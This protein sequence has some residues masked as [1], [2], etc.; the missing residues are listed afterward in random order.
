MKKR[1]HLAIVAPEFPPMTCEKD[2]G[3]CCGPVPVSFKKLAEVRAYC[4]EHGITPLVQDSRCPLFI[5]NQCAIHPIRPRVCQ[6]YGH[7]E[8]LS[9]SRGHDRHVQDEQALMKW[10][11]AD[12]MPETTLHALVGLQASVSELTARKLSRRPNI[13]K[14]ENL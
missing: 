8:K 11:I 3:E 14:K 5:K 12:G 13:F 10:V 2:C 9:C 7:S 6:A 1:K 4:I